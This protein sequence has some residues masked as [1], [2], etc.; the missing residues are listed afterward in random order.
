MARYLVFF[1]I[2][3]TAVSSTYGHPVGA[4]APK[5]RDGEE[6]VSQECRKINN[7]IVVPPNCLPEQILV[8]GQCRDIWRYRVNVQNIINALN[9]C[10][11]GQK[12][13]NGNCQDEWFE[14]G[15]S[16]VVPP[17][18]PNGQQLVNEK[19]REILPRTHTIAKED[20]GDTSFTSTN[21][22]KNTGP[23]ETMH[24]LITNEHWK[25]NSKNGQAVDKKIK[26]VIDVPDHCPSGFKPDGQGVCR[27][28]WT[29]R[30]L[31]D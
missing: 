17:N 24:D 25:I 12:S 21:Q 23:Q 19:C 16:I 7:V 11:P 26:N 3:L 6:W 18:C 28:I 1:V 9:N 20:G 22:E 2:T 8:N 15:N 29:A 31:V 14:I 4:N 10:P 27:P 5:C 30:T 13:I